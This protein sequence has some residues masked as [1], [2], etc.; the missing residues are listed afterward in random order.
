MV[1]TTPELKRLFASLVFLFSSFASQKEE[2][3]IR[4]N[5]GEIRNANQH[6]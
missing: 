2:A 4:V 5:Q 3:T 1:N 6:N